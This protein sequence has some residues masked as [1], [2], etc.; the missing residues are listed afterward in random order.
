MLFTLQRTK[1]LAERPPRAVTVAL[2]ILSLFAGLAVPAKPARA[3][4]VGVVT[5]RI[6][7]D[8][9]NNTTVQNDLQALRVRWV[10][11]EFEE[12]G[13]SFTSPE[14]YD[15]ILRDFQARN[16]RV[17]GVLTSNSCAFKSNT[18]W[19]EQYI[20]N[21]YAAVRWHA[22]RYPWV[23]HWEIWN[24][25]EV[26]GFNTNLPGYGLLL[27]RVFEWAQ[28][29]RRQNVIPAATRIVSAG[30]VNQDI[31]VLRAI[32][33]TQAVN[34]FRNAN[35]GRI[36]CDI[37]AYHPYGNQAVDN[38]PASLRF[39]WN[40]TFEQSWN[41]FQNNRTANGRWYLVPLDLPVWFTEFGFDARRLNNYA[42]FNTGEAKQSA[43]VERMLQVMN[44]YGRIQ[45]AFCYNYNDDRVNNIDR[46]F[47]LRRWIGGPAKPVYTVIDRYTP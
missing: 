42:P 14:R 40:N 22:Q 47:G 46:G 38:D 16:I 17:L 28:I 31:N 4:E 5:G 24:E 1:P 25:P 45:V 44:R 2:T 37:F 27:K 41:Q 20:A 3:V 33:D 29:E 9:F 19:S 32:Y 11:M 34:D 21:F 43:Y 12:H 23:T 26:Y 30:L 36:P 6:Y 18:P 39:N 7:N 15:K 8:L 35:N 13:A 10:R